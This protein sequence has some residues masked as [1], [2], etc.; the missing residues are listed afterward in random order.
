MVGRILTHARKI[1]YGHLAINSSPY[2]GG[3]F[4]W[5]RS[6]STIQ[7]WYDCRAQHSR[8]PTPPFQQAAMHLSGALILGPPPLRLWCP[9]GVWPGHLRKL[10]RFWN[11]FRNTRDLAASPPLVTMSGIIS[12]SLQLGACHPGV[13]QNSLL[14][15][16][17][18]YWSECLLVFLPHSRLSRRAGPWGLTNLVLGID[19]WLDPLKPTAWRTCHCQF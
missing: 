1:V 5:S 10:A 9:Q 12:L 14:R 17:P 19:Q 2:W 6:N 16:H 11:S 7:P 18:L 4:Q 3:R 8:P 13:G 15:E